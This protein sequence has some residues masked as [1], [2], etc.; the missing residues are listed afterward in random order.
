[1]KMRSLKLYKWSLVREKQLVIVRWRQQEDLPEKEFALT[2]YWIQVHDLPL[3]TYIVNVAAR[4]LPRFM[5]SAAVHLLIPKKPHKSCLH[6]QALMDV[7][8]LAVRW[9]LVQL[10]YYGFRKAT[11]K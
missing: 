1:M 9:I 5:T 2:Y 11:T 8:K 3:E 6:I 10:A 4:I 7:S